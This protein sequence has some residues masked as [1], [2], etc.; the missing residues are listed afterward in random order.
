V[1]FVYCDQFCPRGAICPPAALDYVDPS[2]VGNLVANSLQWNWVSSSR[3]QVDRNPRFYVHI[4]VVQDVTDSSLICSV[5]L[6]FFQMEK[7][8]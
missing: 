1:F 2:R 5:V 6:C 4:M 3:V 7:R 8:K